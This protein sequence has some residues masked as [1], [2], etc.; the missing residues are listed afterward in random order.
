MYSVNV[1]QIRGSK[2]LKSV[3]IDFCCLTREIVCFSR[4]PKSNEGEGQR[5]S[6]LAAKSEFG[7]NKIK[8][9]APKFELH[10]LLRLAFH[11]PAHFFL[12]FLSSLVQFKIFAG[13]CPGTAGLSWHCMTRN[14]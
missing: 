4:P 13:V 2:V 5:A 12:S 11:W 3:D 14:L 9:L 1:V 8:N 7:Q 10:L 6:S